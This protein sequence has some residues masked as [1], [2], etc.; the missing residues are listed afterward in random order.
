MSITYKNYYLSSIRIACLIDSYGLPLLDSDYD[1]NLMNDRGLMYQ[2]PVDSKE[3]RRFTKL[4]S[5]KKFHKYIE[6]NNV[7]LINR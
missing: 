1:G 2:S 7:K 4:F 5:S 6:D 3:W